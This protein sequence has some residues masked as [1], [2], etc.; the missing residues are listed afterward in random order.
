MIQA[1]F[2]CLPSVG[3]GEKSSMPFAV[4]KKQTIFWETNQVKKEY[5][6]CPTSAA[7]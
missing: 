5:T 4:V 2:E 7:C 3:M 1:F 6:A